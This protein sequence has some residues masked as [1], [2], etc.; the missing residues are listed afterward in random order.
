MRET[1]QDESG[2]EVCKPDHGGG[3]RTV[4][5]DSPAGEGAE[6]QV[7]N[8]EGDEEEA[9]GEGGEVEEGLCLGGDGGVEGAEDEGLHE[10]EEE[11]GEE[12]GGAEAVEDGEVAD[13]CVLVGRHGVVV[14]FGFGEE[15][16]F[17]GWGGGCFGV[18]VRVSGGVVL[19]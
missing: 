17:F 15:G 16:V 1:E 6:N 8:V 12:T 19:L 7:R 10:G 2:G 9:G 13:Q 4:L 18:I 3:F 14:C 5:I 11:G